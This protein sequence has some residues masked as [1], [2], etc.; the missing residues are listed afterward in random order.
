M[1]V[2][3]TRSP[4]LEALRLYP[5]R[6]ALAAGAFVSIQVNFYIFIA[7][8][9]AYGTDESGRGLLRSTMLSALLI[10][11]VTQVIVHFIAASYTDRHGLK[12]VYLAGALLLGLWSFA[13]L[14]PY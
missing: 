5:R 11:S 14:P 7:F 12:G 13:R 4:V 10:G 6:I 1:L 9:V 3:V 8:V 2:D